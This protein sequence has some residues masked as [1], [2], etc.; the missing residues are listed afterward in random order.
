MALSDD[1]KE[2]NGILGQ[3]QQ[4][5][6]GSSKESLDLAASF[7]NAK[8]SLTDLVTIASKAVPTY[9]ELYDLSEDEVKNLQKQLRANSEKLKLQKDTLAA[10]I[11]LA[12]RKKEELAAGVAANANDL[13]ALRR[14]RAAGIQLKKSEREKLADLAQEEQ[15]LNEINRK[16]KE[17]GDLYKLVEL[18]VDDTNND[19]AKLQKN[20][21]KVAAIKTLGSFFDK[22]SGALGQISTPFDAWLSPLQLITKL[23]SFGFDTVMQYDKRL[24]DTAKSMNMTYDAADKSNRAMVA[25]AKSSG[26]AYANSEGLNR[27]TTELN[28]NLG[29]SVAFEKMGTAL[30]EDINLMSQLEDVAGLT[31]EQTQAIMK[32]S[33]GTGQSAKNVTKELMAS[34]KVQGLKSG[35]VLNEKDAMKAIEKTSKATQMSYGGNAK[36]LGKALA[37]AKGLGVELSKV[38]DIAGSLLNFEESIENELSAELLTGKELNLEKA[39]SAALNNDLATVAEEIT[40]QVGSAADF[41]NMNRIQQDA[42]AKSV[43]MTREELAGSLMEQE[44]LKNIGAASVEDARKRYDTLRETM[45]AEEAMKALGDEAL[46]NQFEQASM[47]EKKEI[48][49]KQMADTIIETLPSMKAMSDSFTKILDTVKAIFEALGGA[50]GLMVIMGT[51][52]AGK[53]VKGIIDFAKGTKEAIQFVRKL[54]LAEVRAAAA[55]IIKTAMQTFAGIPVAGIAL[56]GAAAAAGIGYLMTQTADDAVLPAAGGSGYGKRV[57]FGP[58]GAIQFN[59]KDTIVAGTDL[60][61]NDAVMEPGMAARTYSKGAIRPEGGGGQDMSSVVSAITALANRPV[62]VGI[63]GTKVIE[64]TTGAQPNTFGDATARNSYRMQ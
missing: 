54:K 24:G 33:M 10:Q 6:R 28:K 34:Y 55:S 19:I 14:K 41:A 32:Y 31:G 22:I 26:D 1:A 57:M 7:E 23:L 44:A 15:Q 38:E 9:R 61:A 16:I 56:A 13:A 3:I 51:I 11:E 46:A 30:Q 25:F 50:K 4:G 21:D 49:E 63:D 60:F 59:N 17:S 52:I 48:A 8:N 45:S 29:T 35:L 2:L 43:G 58:E 18:A 64:A 27:V 42:I 5:L 53:M 37:A 36:E 62:N 12:E 20:L 47:A 40:K 39:R